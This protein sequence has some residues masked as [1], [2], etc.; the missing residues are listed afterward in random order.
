M[1]R[2]DPHQNKTAP[3]VY[4]G[5]V[6]SANRCMQTPSYWTTEQKAVIIDRESPGKGF[7]HYLRK[8]D[9]AAFL[10]I[11]PDWADVSRGLNAVIMAR[12]EELTD[13]WYAPGVVAIC[14]WTRDP[15]KRFSPAWFFEHRAVLDRLDVPCRKSGNEYLC[16]FDERSIRGFQ[17]LHVLLHELGHHHDRMHTRTLRDCARG[18]PYAERYSAIGERS[19]WRE[20]NRLFG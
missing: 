10:Q 15:W 1:R 20:Y 11:L 5:K 18:E 9:I 16:M 6:R 13:G 3:R 17:L 12:G 2:R 19:I 7:K 8:N 4:N 14:A